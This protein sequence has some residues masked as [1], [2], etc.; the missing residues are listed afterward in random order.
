MGQ[1]LLGVEHLTSKGYV[2]QPEWVAAVLRVADAV[3]DAPADVRR[4]AV[5]VT[6]HS[7]AVTALLVAHL[8]LRRYERVRPSERWWELEPTPKAAVRMK[9]GEAELLLFRAVHHK[10][11]G[12]FSLRFGTSKG[13]KLMVP[14]IDVHEY[15]PVPAQVMPDPDKAR[16]LDLRSSM[17]AGI[18]GFLGREAVPYALSSD[19]DLVVV[20]RKDEHRQQLERNSVQA[21]DGG[22]ATL[23]AVARVRQFAHGTAYRSRW[24][25][26]DAV[27]ETLSDPATLVLNGGAAVASTIH[28]L[29]D[30][31]WIAVLDRS[32]PSLG[33]AIH[34]V[35]QY[36]YSVETDR[37]ELPG[38]PNE[39]RGH[40]AFLFE[41][42]A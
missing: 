26:A 9:G 33:E 19:P 32:S 24:S 6:P 4:R 21:P 5:I 37:V 17:F 23:A 16:M 25:S 11:G 31:T 10:A 30:H 29:D 18:R 1:G 42:A 12:D 41:T 13:T 8:A 7:D 3:S 2:S 38:W 39:L 40:E 34:Q 14:S 28:D 27:A 22:V 36:Y 15:V 35:E 20:G